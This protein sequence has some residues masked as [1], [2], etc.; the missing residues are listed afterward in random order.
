MKRL[1]NIQTA[2][3]Q[4]LHFSPLRRATGVMTRF[5]TLMVGF[6]LA[7][8]G[9]AWSAATPDPLV[10]PGPGALTNTLVQITALQ[11]EARALAQDATVAGPPTKSATA[12]SK[13]LFIRCWKSGQPRPITVPQ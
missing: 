13:G 3:P 2:I 5:C 8:A 1:M 7:A 11:A 10:E 4:S 12:D 6:W 9:P